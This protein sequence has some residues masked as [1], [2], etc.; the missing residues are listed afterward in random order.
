L[1]DS[2]VFPVAALVALSAAIVLVTP[3]ARKRWPGLKLWKLDALTWRTRNLPLLLALATL[4]LFG[5][6][7]GVRSSAFDVATRMNQQGLD[8]VAERSGLTMHLVVLVLGTMLILITTWPEAAKPLWPRQ[9]MVVA[10]VLLWLQL[11]LLYGT[12]LQPR[13]YPIALATFEDEK[14]SPICGLLVY[15][16]EHDLALWRADAKGGETVS[17]SR[18]AVTMIQIGAT[19]D[20]L[21]DARTASANGSPVPSCAVMMQTAQET[22]Q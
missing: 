4:V 13:L 10:A 9:L 19:R 3:W 21:E 5:N 22:H 16:T 11:P 8:G 20:L 17:L 14:R 7:L 6:A 1:I 12:L 15:A 2:Y 18:E